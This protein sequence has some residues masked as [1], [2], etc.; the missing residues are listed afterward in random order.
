[1]LQKP[2]KKFLQLEG[3]KTRWK[4]VTKEGRIQEILIIWVNIQD[5]IILLKS[6]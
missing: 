5:L 2:L 3:N 4:S 6:L 1:M